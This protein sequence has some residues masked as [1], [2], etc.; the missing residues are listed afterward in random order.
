MRK[1]KKSPYGDIQ[2]PGNVW[3]TLH[4]ANYEHPGGDLVLLLGCQK[5]TNA[6][7]YD[8]FVYKKQ[9]SDRY[10]AYSWSLS[11]PLHTTQDP[12]C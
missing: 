5:V 11:L 3:Q 6:F 2:L 8:V 12:P 9:G 1:F 10:G 4:A 7:M